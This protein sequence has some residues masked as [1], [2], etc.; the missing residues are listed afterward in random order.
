MFAQRPF[1]AATATSQSCGPA[2]DHPISF[3]SG[4]VL[5]VAHPVVPLLLNDCGTEGPDR[6]SANNEGEQVDKLTIFNCPG[7][8]HKIQECNTAI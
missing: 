6:N 2:C 5:V 7:R 4:D 8:N 1:L 3:S